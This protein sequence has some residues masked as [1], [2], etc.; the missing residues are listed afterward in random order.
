MKHLSTKELRELRSRNMSPPPNWHTDHTRKQLERQRKC[1]TTA[2]QDVR[3]AFSSRFRDR[4]AREDLEYAISWVREIRHEIRECEEELRTASAR[5]VIRQQTLRKATRE[6][7]ARG[8]LAKSVRIHRTQLSE[9][10]LLERDLSRERT[11]HR[12]GWKSEWIPPKLRYW[13]LRDNNNWKQYR[14]T[15]YRTK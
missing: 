12:G 2:L 14:K 8:N 6:L 13:E 7:K 1:L 10:E 9:V 5:E 3:A 11:P 15:Q 4:H